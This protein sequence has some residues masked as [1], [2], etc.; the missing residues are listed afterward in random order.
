MVAS[1]E[2][3]QN[4]LVAFTRT[5]LYGTADPIETGYTV[6][7]AVVGYVFGGPFQFIKSESAVPSWEIQLSLI[8][9]KRLRLMQSSER[10]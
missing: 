1:E 8:L 6:E 7:E 4:S 5:I 9:R 10:S 3:N 2:T